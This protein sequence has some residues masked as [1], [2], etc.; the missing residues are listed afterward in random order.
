[1]SRLRHCQRL[2][3]MLTPVVMGLHQ[4]KNVGCLFTTL[5]AIRFPTQGRTKGLV[6]GIHLL[7]SQVG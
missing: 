1:M 2:K 3:G 5:M 4:H 7:L 6:V